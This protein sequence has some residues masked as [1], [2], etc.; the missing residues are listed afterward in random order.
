MCLYY[1]SFKNIHIL[2]QKKIS[3]TGQILFVV[4]EETLY[5]LKSPYGHCFL[6]AVSGQN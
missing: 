4:E 6:G 1:A 3:S 5:L 2:T